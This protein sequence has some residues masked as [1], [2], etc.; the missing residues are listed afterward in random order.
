M[1]CGSVE[2]KSSRENAW[3]QARACEQTT[4]GE[5]EGQKGE[6]KKGEERVGARGWKV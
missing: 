3:Q 6:E 5:R 1:E 2:E 4:E